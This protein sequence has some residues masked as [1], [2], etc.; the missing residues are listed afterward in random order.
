MPKIRLKPN[1]AEYDDEVKE[2]NVLHCEMPGCNK[3]ALH[4]APKDRAL[5]EYY[6][7]CTD[8]II[9]YN[10]A[11]DFFSGMNT[12]EVEEHIYSSQ[13]GNRPTWKYGV[14]DKTPEDHLRDRIWQTYNG[15][16]DEDLK[17]QQEQEK[18][19]H[20]GA[21]SQNFSIHSQEF[22]ALSIMGLEPP[23]TLKEIKKQ[24]KALAKKHHPDMN[25]NSKKS[26]ELL[27]QINMSY[28]I[29]KL[30]YEKFEKLPERD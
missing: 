13:Y 23:T 30:A 8:H 2:N 1:S 21:S 26:E 4:R 11:W 27:K 16:D 24:Y 10:K 15:F 20:T 12:S 19:Q 5:S 3:P 25:Q 22:Q 18:A 17:R 7:F 28:T 14:N 6:H 9:E 29:L